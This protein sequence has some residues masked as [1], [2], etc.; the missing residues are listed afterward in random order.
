MLIRPSKYLPLA[1]T[2]SSRN[3]KKKMPFGAFFV[4][5][6]SQ[7]PANK[8]ISSETLLFACLKSREGL[9]CK[10]LIRIGFDISAFL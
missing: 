1:S 5:M 6:A 3:V 9:F 4:F 8:P 7:A 2:L 10:V